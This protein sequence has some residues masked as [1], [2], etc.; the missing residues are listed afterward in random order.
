METGGGFVPMEFNATQAP[1]FTL[2]GDGT[3]I[4]QSGVM[5]PFGTGGALPAWIKGT[6]SEENIQALLAFALQD[7]RLANAR[8]A[9]DSMMCADCPTTWFTLNAGGA[10][11]TVA[12]N[13][14]SE[15][16]QAGPDAA[17]LAGFS[18]LQQLLANFQAEAESGTATD[19]VPYEPDI[20][21]VTMFE[22]MGAQP[23][24]EPIEWP[25][26]D[27][28]PDD[29]PRGDE[30]GGILMMRSDDVAALAEVPNGGALSI[31]A[32]TPDEELVQFAV[33][34]LLPDEAAAVQ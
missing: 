26:D 32:L 12:I 2:Y 16:Q 17:D 5:P 25:W 21:R 22:A 18:R 6:M 20:Y 8:E 1:T 27:I 9:Y 19:L 33:R 30:P 34:P 3:V 15:V 29:F 4:F 28:A 23:M 13:G 10:S 31:W 11:K 7:G 14:L 24:S